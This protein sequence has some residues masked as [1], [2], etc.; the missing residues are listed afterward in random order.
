MNVKQRV[1]QYLK[2]HP[3]ASSKEVAEA[4][5]TTFGYVDSVKHRMRDSGQLEKFNPLSR[6]KSVTVRVEK[7]EELPPEEKLKFQVLDFVKRKTVKSVE[8]ISDAFNTGISKIRGII[9]ELRKEG[10]NIKVDS[11]NVLFSTVIAKKEPFVLDVSKMSQNSYRFGIV[12]DNHLCSKYERLDVLNA[13]YDLFEKE[14]IK[15]VYNT[16]NWIDGEAKFNKHDLLA[17]GLD[18]QVKYFV[19][20]YP[21]RKG[22]I[23]YFIGGD[24]HEGWYTQREGID[25]GKYAETKAID[26]GRKDLIYL[27]HMEADI[28]LKSKKG[29]TR[30]RVQHPGGGSTYAISYTSQKIV[31]SLT[32]GEK[33]DILFIGHYH[34]A[35][36][37]YV[38]GVHVIQT[39]CTQDQTPFMRKKRI[40]A[41]LGG[42]ILD[43]STDQNGAVTR[44]KPE[45]IPFYDNEYYTQ[46]GYKH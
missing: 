34:K 10:Y 5:L 42:W 13:L 17:H 24:D 27:G 45:F 30:L 4:C 3:T 29:K 15:I 16:G 43:F 35:E 46:W 9:D 2:E 37:S 38:R 20:N 41:H 11:G 21:K 1:Q 12:G 44:F 31:E 23:T 36:Y 28:I 32:S 18:R 26:S 6:R 25:I 14:G 7:K 39:A 8:E 33:P 22:I 19:E 40:A